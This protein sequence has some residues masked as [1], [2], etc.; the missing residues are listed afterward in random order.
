MTE[1]S[2]TP[3]FSPV[4]KSN[5]YSHRRKPSITDKTCLCLIFLAHLFPYNESIQNI[6]PINERE[7][8]ETKFWRNYSSFL[9]AFREA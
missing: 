2:N 3:V 6:L 9:E 5:N 7:R 1:Q 4:D 8:V